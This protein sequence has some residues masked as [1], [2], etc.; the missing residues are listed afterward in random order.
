M[1][2]KKVQIVTDNCEKVSAQA[3][4]IISASRS[5]DIPAF[6]A[7]WFFNRL[8]NGYSAWV[9]P[10]NG[11][12]NYVSY[13]DV[14]FIVFWSK[15]PKPLLKHLSYLRERGINCYIQYTLNDYVSEKLEMGVPPLKDRI[16]TFKRLSD[17]LG[18]DEI[19]WRFD[20]LILTDRISVDSLID[21]IAV[22]GEQLKDYTN[23]LVFSFA[24]IIEYGKVRKNLENSGVKYRNFT[25]DEMNYLASSLSN[26][27]KRWNLELATCAEKI[28]LDKYGI[29]HNRCVDD[30]LMAKIAWQDDILM[31]FLGMEV[32]HHFGSDFGTVIPPDAI[33]INDTTYVVRKKDNKDKG[34]RLLCGCAISKDIGQYNTCVH[35]CEYC[36]ANASKEAARSNYKRHL[37]NPD[38][39][40]IVM[41]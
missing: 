20:P 26:I 19:V 25:P 40:C 36:Y 35:L 2:W 3:P 14:R 10:F 6:Y 27:N 18:R 7:D 8:K 11:V 23:K 39:E 5:T 34:Q 17:Y 24:D 30:Y 38:G 15:N 37:S 28:D 1:N 4:L 33:V 13:E 12:K 29:S 9:N 21:K 16:D 31:K 32:V 22:I 41:E